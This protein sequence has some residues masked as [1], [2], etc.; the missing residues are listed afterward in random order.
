MGS[1]DKLGLSRKE[2]SIHIEETIKEIRLQRLIA[3]KKTTECFRAIKNGKNK[4]EQRSIIE[5]TRKD[6]N[7]LKEQ[8]LTDRGVPIHSADLILKDR[9]YDI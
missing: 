5:Q 6:Y 4:A 7:I 1:R 3:T 9:E 2:W 8:I